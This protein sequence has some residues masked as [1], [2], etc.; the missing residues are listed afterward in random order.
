MALRG[1]AAAQPAHDGLAK[2]P[3][4]PYRMQMTCAA[5]SGSRWHLFYRRQLAPLIGAISRATGSAFICFSHL[6]HTPYFFFCNDKKS[7]QE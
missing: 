2:T 6:A 1:A 4:T 7:L 3:Q 5:Y